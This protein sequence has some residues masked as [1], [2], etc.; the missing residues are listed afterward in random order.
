MARSGNGN[1]D[2]DASADYIGDLVERLVKEVEQALE[3]P[4][5][6][7]P[8]EYYGMVLPC[9]VEIL[10]ALNQLS[11]TASIPSPEV[12][13]CWKSKFLSVRKRACGGILQADDPRHKAI[14]SAFEKLQKQAQKVH[15]D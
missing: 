12:I 7:E 10:A 13:A 5:S 11:G 8:D 15:A 14:R 2:S 9:I 3:N 6:I 4:K 1:F